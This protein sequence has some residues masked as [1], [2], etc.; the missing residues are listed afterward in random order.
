M[1]H[2]A[3]SRDVNS[4]EADIMAIVQKL[5]NQSILAENS[6]LAWK[7]LPNMVSGF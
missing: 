2:E 7:Q 3:L 4:T 1:F 5:I 6:G